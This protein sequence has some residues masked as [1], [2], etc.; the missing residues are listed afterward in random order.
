MD[1]GTVNVGVLIIDDFNGLRIPADG[2]MHLYRPG[3]VDEVV[4]I[5][6]V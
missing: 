3:Y 5:Q 4:A 2:C 1:G 6:R